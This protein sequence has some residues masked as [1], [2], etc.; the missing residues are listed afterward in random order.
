MF[1]HSKPRNIQQLLAQSPLSQTL[2]KHQHTELLAPLIQQ[3]LPANLC[4]HYRVGNITENILRIDVAN[5]MTRYALLAQEKPLLALIQKSYP[6]VSKIQ[7][8][9]DPKLGK[10]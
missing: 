6:M 7:I 10:T 2:K 5:A 8:F 4:Q 3:L 9:I 1:R